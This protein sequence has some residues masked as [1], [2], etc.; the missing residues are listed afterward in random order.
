VVRIT[1]SRGE[2]HTYIVKHCILTPGTY[3]HWV[4]SI[5]ILVGNPARDNWTRPNPGQLTEMRA[6]ELTRIGGPDDFPTG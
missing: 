2:G 3:G 1:E 6:S 4:A 5:V